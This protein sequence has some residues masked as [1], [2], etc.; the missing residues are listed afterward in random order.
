MSLRNGELMVKN[1][2]GGKRIEWGCD[3]GYVE[4]MNGLNWLCV[5]NCMNDVSEM[6]ILGSWLD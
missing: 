2:V 1:R 5:L 6:D 3:R 4:M